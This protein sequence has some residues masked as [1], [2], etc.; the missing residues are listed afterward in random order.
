[1]WIIWFEQRKLS[2][3]TKK[4]KNVTFKLF[5]YDTAVSCMIQMKASGKQI[6]LSFWL[7][8]NTNPKA[9]RSIFMSWKPKRSGYIFF[10][11]I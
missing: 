10:I 2:L 1:M 8:C 9:K 11:F 4:E 5:I 3:H 7:H 6:F